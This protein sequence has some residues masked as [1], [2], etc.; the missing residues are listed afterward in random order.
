M[1][2]SLGVCA[3]LLATQ[4]G[5][6]SQV[7]FG[8]A[9]T[10]PKGASQISGNMQVDLITPK[11]L[12]GGKGFTVPWA[13]VGIGYR[14]GVADRVELG[15]RA[16]FFGLPAN[17]SLGAALDGKVQ[18]LR[19]AEGKGIHVGTGLSL[20]YHQAQLGGTPW[21]SFTAWAPLLFGQDFGPHQ[22][23]LGPRGGASLWTGEGQNPVWV[24]WIGAST[25]V[26]LR[27]VKHTEIMPEIVLVYSPMRFNGEVDNAQV[28]AWLMTFGLSASYAP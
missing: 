21:H 18:L 11:M 6:A 17:H 4:A 16:W 5:C 22:F 27:P 3:T 25:G 12:D 15:G 10:L 14:R 24:P 2:W 7:G 28:G 9:S 19:G 13:H 8:R 26:S 1:R 23:V 20:G